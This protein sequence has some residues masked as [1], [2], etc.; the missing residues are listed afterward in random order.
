MDAKQ[1][2]EALKL[3]RHPKEDGFFRETYRSDESIEKGLPS[4]YSGARSFSTAIFFLIESGRF[5]SFHRLQSEEVFHY[6]AGGPAELIVLES[7]GALNVHTIGPD[8]LAGQEL[9][10]VVPRNKWQALRLVGD[11]P[12][13]LVGCTVAPGFEYI[14]FEEGARADLLREFPQHEQI[15]T[16]LTNC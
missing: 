7:T 9:Q 16:A 4:R 12:W 6:Y 3:Q 13:V 14:D 15:I 2:I 11:A 5:S 1:V 10:V 8:I